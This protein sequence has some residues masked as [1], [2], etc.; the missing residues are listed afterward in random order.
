MEEQDTGAAAKILT[1]KLEEEIVTVNEN[2]DPSAAQIDGN[3]EDGN[4]ENTKQDEPGE[5]KK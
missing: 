1:D 3:P 5:D 4:A 2:L